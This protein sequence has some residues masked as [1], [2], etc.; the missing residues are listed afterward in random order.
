MIPSITGAIS[1]YTNTINNAEASIFRN[2]D[3][4]TS[5][6]N[7]GATMPYDSVSFR[8]LSEKSNQLELD[9]IRDSVAMKYARANREAWEKY[10]D[11]KIKKTHRLS[12]FA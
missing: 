9:N 3:A 4:M 6:M 12:F 2:N 5:L 11:E 10:L 8:A 1:N 7:L